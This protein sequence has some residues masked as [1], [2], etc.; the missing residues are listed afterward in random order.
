[1]FDDRLPASDSREAM[2]VVAGAVVVLANVSFEGCPAG[3]LKQFV[4]DL[5]DV[6]ARLD[7][8][9]LHALAE[10][11][12]RDVTMV[13]DGLRT[14]KWL[15]KNTNMLVAKAKKRVAVANALRTT[16]NEFDLALSDAKIGFD[17]VA[18]LVERSNPRV[19]EKLR[20][21]QLL[22]LD[23][24][25][26]CSQV[27]FWNTQLD[28]LIDQ[29][30][31]DGGYNP[32]ADITRNCLTMSR[33]FD[34]T[35][36][37]TFRLVDEGSVI[38]E[39]ALNIETSRLFAK[40]SKDH[41]NFSEL[42]I[43]AYPVLRGLALIEIVRRANCMR[44][45]GK[46]TRR[47]RADIAL[48]VQAD[49]PSKGLSVEGVRLADNTI[50][51]LCCDAQ[52]ETIIANTVGP[53]GESV[54]LDWGRQ[55]RY[56]T[57]EQ[58]LAAN[59]REGGC[60]FLGCDAK[61]QW[62]DMHH[63]I[64]WESEE[65]GKSNLNN[66]ALLCPLHHG[67]VHRTGWNMTIFRYPPA[68]NNNNNHDHDTLLNP[69]DVWWEF[70]TPL[71]QKFRSQRHGLTHPLENAAA[72]AALTANEV[73]REVFRRVVSSLHLDFNDTDTYIEVDDL[74][75]DECDELMRTKLRL[76]ADP[77]LEI[78][79]FDSYLQHLE[80]QVRKEQSNVA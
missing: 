32:D 25:P 44:P 48:I 24:V 80:D 13:G 2:R 66:Y 8:A 14:V 40:Y 37:A 7:A 20:E 12:A 38:V 42:E 53:H 30:D 54:P 35:L 78:V 5:A 62:S 76:H 74:T 4:C 16:F 18:S 21:S 22:L 33:T 9:E 61:A 39:Q 63:V 67:V 36:Q 75:A 77:N 68:N 27:G 31:Q 51:K 10:M 43:P 56:A 72:A 65:K 60:V 57:V 15:A 26:Y 52:F 59:M 49:K 58:F 19:E 50:R 3:S 11:E 46:R 6:R 34:G 28:R 45:N 1:M 79:T 69:N 70:T 23:L 29:V 55:K 71:G 17:H 47:P 73:E 41:K 64:H